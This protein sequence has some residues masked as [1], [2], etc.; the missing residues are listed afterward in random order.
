MAFVPDK[1]RSRF[2]PDEQAKEKTIG[3]TL[4]SVYDIANKPA[5][6][7]R[8]GL[9]M[10][11]DLIPDP[12]TR[13]VALNV[14][15]G[16]PKTLLE[17]GSDLSASSISPESLATMAIPAGA[18]SKAGTKLV[19]GAKS[20][21]EDKLPAVSQA[22]SGVDKKYFARIL[23]NPKIA[24]PEWMGGPKNL[25]AAGEAMEA[26]E[27]K[28]FGDAAELTAREINDPALS[29]ARRNAIEA[30]DELKKVKE[31]AKTDPEFAAKYLSDPEVGAK[32]LKG[33]RG[34]QAQLDQPS[35]KGSK[36]AGLTAQK[37]EMNQ[38][39]DDY[40]PM[41]GDASK[42]Y[43]MSIAR[44]KA[45]G[46]LPVLKNGDPSIMRMVLSAIGRTA[47][48]PFGVSMPMTN[49]AANALTTVGLNTLE[50]MVNIP[51]VKGIVLAEIARRR[52]NDANR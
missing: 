18:V 26:A 20:L 47:G 29:V 44:E 16:T 22:L 50:K 15:L 37:E 11:T 48:V 23:K 17:V 3:D 28:A 46:I 7:S 42:D 51:S 45:M 1:P 49:A 31:I 14:V 35:T 13:S 2:V 9:Q 25:R 34:T 27:K 24:L 12:E 30:A 52:A 41:I 39:L 21:A 6:M 19:R 38:I 40:F 10:L 43:A 32:I 4:K 8:E 36:K 5:K 33:K